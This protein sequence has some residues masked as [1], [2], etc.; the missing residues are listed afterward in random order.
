ML[1]V[2]EPLLGA[3]ERAAAVA[4]LESGWITLGARV[5]E[6]ERA[7]ANRHGVEDAVAVDSCTAALHLTLKALGIGAGDEVLAPSL[8]FVATI[9]AILYAGADPVLVDIEG[10]DSP[11]MSI[12]DAAHKITPRT[13]A[14]MLM[15]FAGHMADPGPWR[16]FAEHHG[17]LLIEDAAHAIGVPGVGSYGDGA[18]F[19]FYGN[20]NMTTAEGGMILMRDPELLEQARQMRGHGMTR[21][22]L[23][24]LVARSPHYDVDMLGF[25]Y[26]MDEIRAAIGL[27]QLSKLDDMNAR[28]AA[29]FARY[30]EWLGPVMRRHKGLQVPTSRS[31]LSAHH[32]MP[33]VLPETADRD[34]V[35]ATMHDAGIQTTIHYPPVHTLSYYRARA[36]LIRLPLTEEFHRREL[37]LP[38]HPKME[39]ADV[40]RVVSVLDKTLTRAEETV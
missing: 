37:T 19:S 14:V 30:Q 31:G 8:T 13:R 10:L 28:R 24:R 15:H 29:L 27:V 25:N 38:L 21:T 6:F 12:E 23:Q 32:I 33:V 2:A 26:R 20:K 16:A 11:L 36:P 39:D 9:N 40:R 3:E 34:A 7:F 1:L 4:V 22:V 18:A 35:T 17:L 5:R